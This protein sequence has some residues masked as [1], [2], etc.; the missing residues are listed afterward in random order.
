MPGSAG[1]HQH[2]GRVGTLS[3][4]LGHAGRQTG[5]PGRMRQPPGSASFA[6]A[7]PPPKARRRPPTHSTK[8]R[9]N[10]AAVLNAAGV[11]NHFTAAAAAA[12]L[13]APAPVGTAL[14]CGGLHCARRIQPQCGRRSCRAAG[15]RWGRG[16]APARPNAPTLQPLQPPATVHETQASWPAG[17][18]ASQP[19]KQQQHTLDHCSRVRGTGRHTKGGLRL[20]QVLRGLAHW[21]SSGC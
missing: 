17:Q 7:P 6:M 11:S 2:W 18:S 8:Q 13:P 5:T 9:H 12:G 3:T 10:L 4:R 14:R 1:R 15:V 16:W 19:T 21:E 20:L